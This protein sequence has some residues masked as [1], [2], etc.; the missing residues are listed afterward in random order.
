MKALRKFVT[1]L[2]ISGIAVACGDST[3]TGNGNGNGGITVADIAGNYTATKFEY[4]MIDPPNASLDLI[5]L[6][7]ELTVN[8]ATDGS[9]TASLLN[10]LAPPAVSFSGTITI[11]GSTL[12]LTVSDT[13]TAGTIELLPEEPFV[14]DTFT[15]SGDQL[16]LSASSGIDFDFG[17]GAVP[18]TLLL[19]ATRS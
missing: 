17:A 1:L 15:L 16:T 6:T 4:T 18:A 5:A 11:S 10:P 9:F 13:V 8:I 7:G 19:I 12:T 3:D 14:F 2:A